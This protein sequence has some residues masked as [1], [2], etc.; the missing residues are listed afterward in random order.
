MQ[1]NRVLCQ[2]LRTGWRP[3]TGD[4]FCIG[5]PIVLTPKGGVRLDAA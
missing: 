5:K 2:R 4:S 1:K 3:V